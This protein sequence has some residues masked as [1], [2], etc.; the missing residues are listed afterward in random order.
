MNYQHVMLVTWA[1]ESQYPYL[2]FVDCHLDP[3]AENRWYVQS[4]AWLQVHN[5]NP[6]QVFFFSYL[7]YVHLAY[8]EHERTV[9][10]G[11]SKIIL[12]FKRPQKHSQ[13]ERNLKYPAQVFH[14]Q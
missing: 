7:R 9:T 11:F 12:W 3:E 2:I 10:E 8:A 5:S 6:I 13:D 1:A 14:G 4:S